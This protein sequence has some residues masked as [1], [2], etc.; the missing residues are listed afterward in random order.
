MVSQIPVQETVCMPDEAQLSRLLGLLYDAAED[1]VHWP[2]ALDAIG[3]R[4]GA[5]AKVFSIED[6]NRRS[7]NIAL[8]VGV[9]PGALLL[10]NSY[11]ESVNIH[12][13]RARPFVATGR[14][15]ATHQFCSDSETLK[16]EFYNDFLRPHG[17]WFYVIG[18]RVA[19]A[20]SLLSVV[21]F[22]RPRSA[23]PFETDEFRVLELLS[24]HFERA[25]R[26][27]QRLGQYR[28]ARE[29]LDQH[30]TAMFFLTSTG[31]V[32][33]MNR[34][35]AAIVCADDGIG[36]RK[37]GVIT[38]INGELIQLV[39]QSA[40]AAYEIGVTPRNSLL[41]PRPSG[42]K[43]YAV[44]VSRHRRS[45]SIAGTRPGVVVFV[46]DRDAPCSDVTEVLRNA[47]G[48]TPAEVRLAMLLAEDRS[49]ENSC[50]ELNIRRTT[51]RTHLK[52]IF[53]KLS[54]CRQSELVGFVRQ[55][56]ALQLPP[57]P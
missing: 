19:K 55:L 49:L 38:A 48:L 7:S 41:V 28:R 13:Q 21:H 18:F 29:V 36:I 33:D 10:Y 9:D 25:A 15:V 23:G 30:S 17:H 16:S 50:S 47:Y 22:M 8:A 2:E 40:R 4:V 56:A 42:R 12:V 54:I 26:L 53:E 11:Y 1:P 37:D 32:E 45:N 43:P 57:A 39:H 20:A 52:N 27:H 3:A 24:P 34:A 5:T 46:I 6:A 35:A 44:I 31:H 14:V 51:G